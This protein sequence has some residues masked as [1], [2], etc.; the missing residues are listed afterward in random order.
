MWATKNLNANTPYN[1]GY[2]YRFAETE[3]FGG[4]YVVVQGNT[5]N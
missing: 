4:S 1:C 2:H 5:Q 3:S